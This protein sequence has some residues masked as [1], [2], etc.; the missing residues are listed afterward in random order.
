MARR[1]APPFEEGEAAQLL[2]E[3]VQIDPRNPP[4]KEEE[5]AV[6]IREWLADNGVESRLV[7][8]AFA[9]RPQ[10]IAEVGDATPDARTLVLN[11]HMDVV[12]PGDVE[13]W[14]YEPFGGEIDGGRAYGRGTSSMK[15]GLAAGTPA[16]GRP[17]AR[18]DRFSGQQSVT[19][20]SRRTRR[21][22]RRYR[23]RT[24]GALD[25]SA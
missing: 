23:P 20:A 8:E 3:L 4:G 18:Q 21:R 7:S 14:T 22:T 9:D 12:A 6:Y 17:I 2:T 16:G 25:T 1:I 24:P 11:G 10:V 5:C 15:A 13:D 19:I